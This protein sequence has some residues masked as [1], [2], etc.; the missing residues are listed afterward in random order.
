MR[1]NR[2][3]LILLA[4]V[5]CAAAVGSYFVL[6]GSEGTT[7]RI[8]SDG[9]LVETIEL[10]LVTEEYSFTVTGPEGGTNT[11]TV[12]PGRICVSDADCPD[13]V[14]VH[15]GWISNGTV[16]VVCLPNRLVIEISGTG[17][18]DGVSG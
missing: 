11:V 5:L 9:E 6:R 13:R 17:S 16:P 18:V 14:C 8:Y 2:F 12:E 4:A 3:W 15:Q 10:S 7:A 1:S